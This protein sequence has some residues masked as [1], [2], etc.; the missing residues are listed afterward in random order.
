M[1][2]TSERHVALYAVLVDGTELDETVSGRVREVRI[3][4]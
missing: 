4:S 3:L 2:A 1:S